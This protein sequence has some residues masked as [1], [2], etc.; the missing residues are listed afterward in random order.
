M[1][2][3]TTVEALRKYGEGTPDENLE[4]VE[5]D[6]QNLMRSAEGNSIVAKGQ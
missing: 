4:D 3:S 1:N 2:I 6:L 5:Q